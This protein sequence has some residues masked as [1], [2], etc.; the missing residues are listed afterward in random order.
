MAV[1][2]VQLLAFTLPRVPLSHSHRIGG[3]RISGLLA[4]FL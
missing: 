2:V 1:G 4:Y 3:H